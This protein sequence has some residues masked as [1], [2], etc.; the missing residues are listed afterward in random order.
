MNRFYLPF[1]PS[2]CGYLAVG[3]FSLWISN[4]KI[5]LLITV[6]EYFIYLHELL[7]FKCSFSFL[8]PGH[9]CT[10][11]G[12]FEN[13]DLIIRILW[14]SVVGRPPIYKNTGIPSDWIGITYTV[15]TKCI[16]VV[17]GKWKILSKC[18]SLGSYVHG[19]RNIFKLRLIGRTRVIV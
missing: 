18:F 10:L 8:H 15:P 11:H 5:L 19:V 3:L 4:N 17:H 9:I 13:S 14:L 1:S 2:L 12:I 16:F 7:C 6:N